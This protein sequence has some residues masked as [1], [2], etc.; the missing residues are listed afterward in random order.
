LYQNHSDHSDKDLHRPLA[1]VTGEQFLVDRLSLGSNEL[2]IERRERRDR[3]STHTDEDKAGK[4]G[5][6]LVQT[7]RE[8]VGGASS[9]IYQL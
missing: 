8:G 3:L 6:I 7:A 9:V 5:M 2:S 1:E 4:V